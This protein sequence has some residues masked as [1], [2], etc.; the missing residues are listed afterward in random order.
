MLLMSAWILLS[1]RSRSKIVA[2]A[3]FP[4]GEKLACPH[5]KVESKYQAYQ[6]IY[7]G[8]DEAPTEMG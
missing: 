3:K 2:R 4:D 8:D 5:C 1:K 6:L 7:R